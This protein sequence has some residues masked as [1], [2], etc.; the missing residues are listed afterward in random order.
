[1]E[2]EI[3]VVPMVFVPETKAIRHFLEE[4]CKTIIKMQVYLDFNLME[5]TFLKF[6][7]SVEKNS[8]LTRTYT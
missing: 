4:L 5:F 1:M 6:V 3:V 7:N 8:F 2:C